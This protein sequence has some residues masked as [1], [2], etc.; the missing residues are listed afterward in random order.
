MI[1]GLA[2]RFRCGAGLT[3]EKPSPLR[4]QR[5]GRLVKKVFR[6]SS[7]ETLIELE[8]ESP[9]SQERLPG[10]VTSSAVEPNFA[11]GATLV[12][13]VLLLALITL[14]CFASMQLVGERISQR[15]SVV[16]SVLDAAP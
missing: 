10:N 1:L 2:K 9:S 11:R 6:V 16:G 3:I 12:E 8:N 7:R 4:L 13:Y 15:F 5:Y 14:I